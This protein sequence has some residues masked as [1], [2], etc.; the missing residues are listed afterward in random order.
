MFYSKTVL[1]TGGTGGLGYYAAL[2]IAKEKPNYLV[3]ITGRSE[4]KLNQKNAVFLP[5]DLAPLSKVRAFA[6]SW[7]SKNYPPIIALILNAGMQSLGPMN[8]NSDGYETHFAVNHLG[9]ALLFHLL[10]PSLDPKARII[11][12]ASENHDPVNT[13]KKGH[14]DAMYTTAE[15]LAHPEKEKAHPNGMQR[16]NTSKLANILWTYA[17]ARH[18]SDAKSD[19]MVNAFNPGFVPG[20]GLLR[21][22][23]AISR[24]LWFYVLPL[25]LPLLR[26][27]MPRI[28]E[29]KAIGEDLAWIATSE[30]T[31][32]VTGKYFDGRKEEITSAA[33]YDVEKQED[34]WA[35]TTKTVGGGADVLAG[36]KHE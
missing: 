35:W 14:P 6:E 26:M 17:L 19:I 36:L 10:T 1:L 8:L 4:P 33:S 21:E 12:T 20:T 16:Y 31:E 3:V 22:Y 11:V 25:I 27:V 34:L 13:Q 29:T 15:A 32:H 5:L 2:N 9:H 30:Q 18:L 24:F 23:G 7:P 28:R